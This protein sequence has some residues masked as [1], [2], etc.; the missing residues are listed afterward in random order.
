MDQHEC[1]GRVL[2]PGAGV[3]LHALKRKRTAAREI[4][5]EG[6][7]ILRALDADTRNV[8]KCACV[9]VLAVDRNLN[10]IT[11][12]KERE[13]VRLAV[14]GLCAGAEDQLPRG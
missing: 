7:A 12:P 6:V 9:C 10:P 4:D 2:R 11:L 8:R 5:G 13:R 14:V 1:V 3:E